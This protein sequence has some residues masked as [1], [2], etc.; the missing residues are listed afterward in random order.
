M[1]DDDGSNCAGPAATRRPS[2]IRER[3]REAILDAA[4]EVF[5]K[6]GFRGATLDEIAGEAGLSKPNLL[7]YFRSKSAMHSALL[8]RIL[9]TW[10]DPLRALDE[11]GDPRGEILGYVR[12][13]MEMS[14]RYPR[15]SRLF[16]NE[17]LQGAPHV[18]AR[19][20]GELRAV[21]DEKA[22]VIAGWVGEERLPP[23]DGHHLIISIWALTQHYADFEVQIGAVLGREDP[24][25]R[26]EAFLEMLFTRLMA[27]GP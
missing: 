15:E 7:Y 5:S 2:R 24:Y 12:G 4:L 6:K 14:R 22:A 18:A 11:T 20:S 16:A 9:S 17:V 8:E 19:L 23:L 27:P 25:P 3:N 1:R 26:A 21:V 13:K 10:L